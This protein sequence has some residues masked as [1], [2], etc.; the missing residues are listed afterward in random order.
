MRSASSPSLQESI[1]RAWHDPG[2]PMGSHL[3]LIVVYNVGLG[4]MVIAAERARR[5][6]VRP[7]AWDVVLLGLG[8]YKISRL[9]ATDRVTLPLRTPFVESTE[10][11]K[12]AG[13]GLR[14]ALGELLTC[15]HC[16]AP[17]AALGLGTGLAFA[18]RPTR[19]ACGMFAAM[20]LADV[21]HRSYSLLS[22]RQRRQR[23]R[24]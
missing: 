20:T 15:P 5:L 17:W 19:F 2:D 7:A 22:E 10:D 1:E 6:P 3:G 23:T 21:L 11:E 8:T 14:R 18:P 9:V 24:G 13:K 16:V 12:P 4:A